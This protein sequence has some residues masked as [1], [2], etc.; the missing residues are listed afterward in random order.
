[1]QYSLIVMVVI[2][3]ELAAGVLLILFK[4]DVSKIE[5][6]R[7]IIFY[8]FHSVQDSLPYTIENNT[9]FVYYELTERSS[10]RET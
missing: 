10:T 7:R 1:M 4:S 8:E 2:G 6:S 5:L 3:S 9:I